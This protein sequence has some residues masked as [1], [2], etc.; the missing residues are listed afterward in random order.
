MSQTDNQFQLLK[1]AEYASFMYYVTKF[2][3]QETI[4]KSVN[5]TVSH[6][7]DLSELQLS[8]EC[9]SFNE[10]SLVCGTWS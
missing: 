5:Q 3:I 8:H 4:W 10:T 1:Q 6:L 9:Q 2:P 7:K